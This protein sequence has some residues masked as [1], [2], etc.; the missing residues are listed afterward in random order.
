MRRALDIAAILTAIAG[1]VVGTISV[2]G[3]TPKAWGIVGWF[4]SLISLLRILA[5]S[6]R[7]PRYLIWRVGLASIA[8]FCVVFLAAMAA[9]G[10]I[11]GT[12][13]IVLA[14]VG[15]TATAMVLCMTRI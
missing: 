3:L 6:Q 2:C 15:A 7:N 5:I 13:P 14:V 9:A 12:A 1:V 4:F 8:T 10:A 11:E